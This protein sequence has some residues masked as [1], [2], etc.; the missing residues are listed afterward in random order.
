MQEALGMG[1]KRVDFRISGG[2]CKRHPLRKTE[3]LELVKDRIVRKYP[4]LY[5]FALEKRKERFYATASTKPEIFQ[6]SLVDPFHNY[7]FYLYQIF[8]GSLGRLHILQ[9]GQIT[10]WF[11]QVTQ[12]FSYTTKITQRVPDAIG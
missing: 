12:F 2:E 8:S 6:W 7:T 3:C 9:H 10:F 5:T 11:S 1:L 4:N